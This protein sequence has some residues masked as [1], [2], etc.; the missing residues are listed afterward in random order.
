MQ[1]S[2]NQ[3]PV[4][5]HAMLLGERYTNQRVS[6]S[7]MY[8]SMVQEALLASEQTPLSLISFSDE[9]LFDLQH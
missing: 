8:W 6:I 9:I 4:N 2:A 5:S 7:V 3:K 1:G